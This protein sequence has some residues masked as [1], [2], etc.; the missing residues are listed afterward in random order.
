M[1]Q[2]V[3]E[4]PS[5]RAGYYPLASVD[6]ILSAH[7]LVGT[8]VASTFLASVNNAAVNVGVQISLF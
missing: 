3:P 2:L 6:H 4:F 7:P 5:F 1:L 8:W